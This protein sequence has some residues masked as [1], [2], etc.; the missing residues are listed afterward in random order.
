[1][2]PTADRRPRPAA[3]FDRDGV[4]NVD[5]GYVHA[6][7]RL[8]LVP[9]AATALRACREA[10]LLVFVVTNQ[11]GVARGYFEEATLWTFHRHL[12]AVLA[13][14][15][16]AIDDLRYC[17][18]LPDAPLPA[19]RRACDWRKPGPGMLLDLA[20]AWN[21]DLP[22]SFLVGDKPSDMEAAMAAGVAGHL[23]AGGDLADFVHP[24]LE[25]SLAATC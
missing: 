8:E 22:R 11:S 25:R 5:H 23:F 7:D 4:I 19:Y 24:I 12:R 15:G 14:E 21:V 6:A 3:F 18:H 16:A 13:G 1:M 2:V 10:G 9:G 17:P 20:R